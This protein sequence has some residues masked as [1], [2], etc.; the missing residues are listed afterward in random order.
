LS[1]K[2]ELGQNAIDYIRIK[3]VRWGGMWRFLSERNLESG[4]VF[5]YFP[6]VPADLDLLDLEAGLFSMEERQRRDGDWTSREKTHLLAKGYLGDNAER[7]GLIHSASLRPGQTFPFRERLPLGYVKRSKEEPS[8]FPTEIYVYLPGNNVSIADVD[9]FVETV[10]FWT[11]TCAL[12]SSTR[13]LTSG[14]E[15]DSGFFVESA[16]KTEHILRNACDGDITLVWSADKLSQDKL[17][18]YS[19]GS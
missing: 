12:T 3:L 6:K 19:D 17:V 11:M 13:A 16:A 4:C 18:S 10:P 2:I 9:D 5:A 15:I 14:A 7:L 1:A 8:E